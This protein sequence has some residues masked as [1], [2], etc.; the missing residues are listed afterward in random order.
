MK[1]L[2]VLLVLL[3]AGVMQVHAQQ[4]I[5]HTAGGETKF[6]ELDYTSCKMTFSNGQMEFHVGD[7]VKNTIAIKDIQRISFYGLQSG[8]ATLSDENVL[9][10]S[11]ETESLVACVQPGASVVV[12]SIDG[13][14]VLSHV[15]TITSSVINVAHLPA[16]VY[17]AVTGNETLKFVR[18]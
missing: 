8:V 14:R 6:E 5:V 18:P 16:G 17:V 10:Y 1:Y 15:Q 3:F 2:H 11:S 13:T 9:V 7:A 12:Y 4:M